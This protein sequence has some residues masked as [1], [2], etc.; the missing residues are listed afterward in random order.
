MGMVL[1]V[2]GDVVFD[3]AL[4]HIHVLTRANTRPVANA[5]NMGVY[6]LRRH[7]P[8]HVQ[9]DIGGLAPHTRQRLK[10]L[11]ANWGTSPPYSSTKI[12]LSFIT[13]L[14]F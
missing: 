6:G 2:G 3:G 13:F 10:G 12:W 14:A 1:K 7:A 11:R 8:P 5:E 4:D 9:N